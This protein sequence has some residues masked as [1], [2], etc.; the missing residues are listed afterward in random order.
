MSLALKAYL[1]LIGQDDDETATAQSLP[2]PRDV[3]KIRQIR[4][5]RGG[6]A[7]QTGSASYGSA[8]SGELSG[9]TG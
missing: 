4:K 7:S 6:T 9:S 1:Q 5:A 8:F 3:F 2:P